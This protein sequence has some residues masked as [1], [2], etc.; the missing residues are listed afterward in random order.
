MRAGWCQADNADV[1]QARELADRVLLGT[2]QIGGTHDAMLVVAAVLAVLAVVEAGNLGDQTGMDLGTS[3]LL[4]LMTTAPLALLPAQPVAVTLAVTLANAIMLGGE[5]PPFV[6]GVL[7]ELLALYWLGRT[8]SRKIALP[9]LLPFV[10][11]ALGPP[12]PGSTCCWS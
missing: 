12:D 9:F 7:A 5:E 8:R 2:R 4:G 6:A 3:L 1:S 10:L 11:F